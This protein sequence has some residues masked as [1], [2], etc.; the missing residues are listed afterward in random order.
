MTLQ[1]TKLT[2]SIDPAIIL[3]AKAYATQQRVS[4]SQLVENYLKAIAEQERPIDDVP[5]TPFVASLFV[6]A[7]VP[8]DVE[9]DP[10]PREER[11]K[12]HE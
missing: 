12:K 6:G 9:A 7:S 10:G 8:L 4:L 3:I 5:I 2:L 1:K 11:L